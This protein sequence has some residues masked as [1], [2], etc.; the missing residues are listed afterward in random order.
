VATVAVMQ[1]TLGDRQHCITVGR[2]ASEITWR[3]VAVMITSYH[4]AGMVYRAMQ[5]NTSR[6]IAVSSGSRVY[7]TMH[8]VS[9]DHRNG[10]S[11]GAHIPVPTDD[12]DERLPNTGMFYLKMCCMDVHAMSQNR[13][14]KLRLLR[15]SMTFNNLVH[16]LIS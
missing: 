9:R 14:T 16:A 5:T 12:L 3:S 11:L 8:K 15:T 10:S 4:V 13:H 2:A 7:H 6:L 1:C